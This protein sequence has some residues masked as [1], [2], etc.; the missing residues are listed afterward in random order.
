MRR[1]G[2]QLLGFGVWNGANW[3][4]RRR[5]CDTPRKLAVG[6]VVALLLGALL[7]AQRRA[8]SDD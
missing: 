2:Y 5:Y 7:F 8:S 4:V 3:Y 1:A 6:G